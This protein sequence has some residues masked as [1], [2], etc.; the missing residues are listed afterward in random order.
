MP[1]EKEVKEADLISIEHHALS[2]AKDLE[3]TAE[4]LEKIQDDLVGNHLPKETSE[5]DK[6]ATSRENR[7]DALHDKFNW[8]QESNSRLN[9]T[10][11]YLEEIIGSDAI[12]EKK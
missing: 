7:I 3:I 9:K 4:R 2:A 1:T 8:I 10:C 5:K 11:K 6:S 12:T